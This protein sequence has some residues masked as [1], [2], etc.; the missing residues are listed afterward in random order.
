MRHLDWF[1]AVLGLLVCRPPS[2][3]P[4]FFFKPFWAHHVSSRVINLSFRVVN[5]PF[6]F[7]TAVLFRVMIVPFRVSYVPVWSRYVRVVS[8]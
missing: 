8:G 4:L 3:A 7:I 5:V 6:R 2:C 1:Y